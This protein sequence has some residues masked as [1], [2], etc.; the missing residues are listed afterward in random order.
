M[1]KLQMVDLKGQYDSIRTEIDDAIQRV[2][3][4][5]SFIRGPE[6]V[7]F[8]SELSEY[9]DKSHVVSV[10][11]GT[12]ALQVAFMALGLG[13]GDEVITPSFTFV[14]TGEA[15]A[16]LGA[17]PVFADID[18]QTFTIDPR[19]I[20]EL[21]TERTRAIVPVHLFGQTCD[22]DPI[23][24]IARRHN[25]AV[26]EDTAQAIGA[27]YKGRHAGCIG[28]IGTFSFFP[29]KNLGAYGDAGA[30]VTADD[31]FHD[32]I[33]LVSNHG[34]RRK[35]ENEIVGVNSRLDG[36]Q[37]AI[38]R[39]KLQYLD[40]FNRSR[41]E[42]ADRYDELLSDLDHV[43][44]PFRDPNGLHVF[45]QYTIR[46]SVSWNRGRQALSEH[47]KSKNIPHA[48]YYPTPLHRLPVF[49]TGEHS[50]R[51]GSMRNTDLAVQEVLSLPMHTELD[52]AQQHF[53][54]D[55]I[56]RFVEQNG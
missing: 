8:E 56:R 26:V 1:K 2:I 22:M 48:V 3:D 29:S 30:V 40:D 51:T 13:D 36:I 55:T 17:V 33:R 7:A 38:L 27:T 49:L 46:I 18:P 19:S 42:A 43:S 32:R 9:L 12:D 21:I 28:D 10:G 5:S 34:S 53:I 47:L 20:E 11:N 14:A 37:A 4:N 23:M 25:L 24:D 6:G 16:L 50:S 31:G 39:V 15:A 52:E 45:H 41:R 44:V 54:A 35:Y